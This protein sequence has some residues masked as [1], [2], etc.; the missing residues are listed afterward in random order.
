MNQ[1][2]LIV[3]DQFIEANDLRLMLQ[4][5]G[6]R[7]TGIARSVPNALELIG[8]EKP[9]VVLLDI[10]LKGPL[11][12][13]DL[14]KQL[15]EDSIPFIYLSANS[16]QDVLTA[17]KATQPDGFLVKPF[18]EKDVLVT[19]EVA[20]YRHEHSLEASFRRGTQ[21]LKQLT[22]LLADPI[23]W[24][25]KLLHAGKAIQPFIPFDFMSAGLSAADATAYTDQG[26]LRIGFDEYQLVGPT[27]L[28]VM[29]NLKRHEL[30]ALQAKTAIE[31]EA[32]W[33]SE[34]E[35][36]QVCRQPSIQKLIADTFLMRSHLVLPLAV[37]TGEQFTFSFYSRRPDAY[38]EEHITLFGQLKPVLTTA[39]GNLL[40]TSPKAAPSI[41]TS[42][43]EYV[44]QSSDSPPIPTTFEGIV[45]NSHL[46]LTVFDHLSLVAP[47]DTSVLILGESGTGKERI[48]AT[49][50]QLS[51]RK[52]KP[53]I[54]VN[55]A[56]LPANLIESELFGHEKGSFTGATDKRIG[57]FEQAD[58]GSIFLDEIGEMPVELQVKL[59]RVLQEKEIERIG[60][61]S[62]IKIN[63]R[64]IAATNR[65]LEK[66]VAEG[67]FRLDLYYRLNVFP[68]ALPPL[69]DRKED[70]PALVQH[71]IGQYNQKTGKKITGLSAHALSSLLS[72]HWPGNIRELEHLIERSV[73]LTKGTLIEEVGL[74]NMGQPM[75]PK[76]S[77]ESRLKTID[78]NERDHII[79][80]LKKCNGRIWGAGGAAEVLNVPPTTLNSKMKKLGIRKEYL[81][82]R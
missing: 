23:D 46:L 78:E 1:S 10:F 4:K 57:R 68:I 35:F 61:Q 74:P 24:E 12:G 18:R 33:Y 25:Q 19:L 6:Y 43:S 27:E 45:G 20:R 42:T 7:V 36:K 40:N 52:R 34:I 9:D 67:R 71:F 81:D 63:V 21:L 49:I 60:G 48:A 2:V 29:T 3:E 28:M 59:L 70:I 62:S 22:K 51:P 37:P 58:G 31:T 77:E 55:C 76:T 41:L 11:T 13:I 66:E 32:I 8:Q 64:I 15:K 54:R 39:V 14:A 30:A 44:S 5:A 38:Q 26:Y 79:A 53:L 72:Y 50:H 69:R 73:L 16:T 17:A 65:N 80:V 56:T 82:L 75:L 47:S